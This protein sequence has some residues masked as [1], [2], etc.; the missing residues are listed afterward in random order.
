MILSCKLFGCTGTIPGD[1]TRWGIAMKWSNFL[2]CKVKR[3]TLDVLC[4]ALWEL[5]YHGY[6]SK[7]VDSFWEDMFSHVAKINKEMKEKE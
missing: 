2:A 1:D 7:E 4:N 5:T 6:S 3:G